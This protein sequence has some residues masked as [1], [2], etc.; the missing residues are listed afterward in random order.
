MLNNHYTMTFSSPSRRQSSRRSGWAGQQRMAGNQQPFRRS[1]LPEPT[2]P[3]LYY[4]PS[5]Q[6]EQRLYDGGSRWIAA[7]A[8]KAA[9]ALTLLR[10][11]S[12]ARY[13]GVPHSVQVLPFTR[14]ANPKSVTWEKKIMMI[15][16]SNISCKPG[17]HN[18]MFYLTLKIIWKLRNTLSVAVWFVR[19]GLHLVKI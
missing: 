18:Q 15:N 9:V 1:A 7:L 11:I 6:T 16:I 12:G 5:T 10:M 2:S 19:I 4:S 13:S 8:H 17:P 14:L 3:R